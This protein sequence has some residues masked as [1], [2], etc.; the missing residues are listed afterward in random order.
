M[1]KTYMRLI[2]I[3]VLLIALLA[4]GMTACNPKGNK[5]NAEIEEP[6]PDQ[7]SNSAEETTDSSSFVAASQYTKSHKEAKGFLITILVILIILIIVIVFFSYVLCNILHDSQVAQNRNKSDVIKRIDS[8]KMD[9]TAQT[10]RTDNKEV[11]EMLHEL[12]GMIKQLSSGVKNMKID[13]PDVKFPNLES[14][15]ITQKNDLLSSI[16]ALEVNENIELH[17]EQATD[18][19][20]D[21]INISKEI[22]D[23]IKKLF[24]ILEPEKDER[25]MNIRIHFKDS[26]ELVRDRFYKMEKEAEDICSAIESF[27]KDF[28]LI[29]SLH[30]ISSDREK[31]E[32]AYL[33]LKD[34]LSDYEVE[35]ILPMPRDE[36]D[37]SIMDQNKIYGDSNKVHKV[38]YPGFR[39]ENYQ[40]KA[41]VDVI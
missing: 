18:K 38:V 16:R 5:E 2:T 30:A 26:Y 8:M 6:L 14:M 27:M 13:A 35:L 34:I 1:N 37:E 12:A 32:K 41:E 24:N 3:I 11:I 21:I 19:L 23:N 33:V 29:M 40:F 22:Q 39:H 31:L 7:N 9:H 4:M 15:M 10:G 36:Y 17:Y 25:F 20:S 28:S